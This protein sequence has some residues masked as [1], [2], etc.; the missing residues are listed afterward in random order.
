M[1]DKIPIEI[2]GG[3]WRHIDYVESEYTIYKMNMEHGTVLK[4]T[5]YFMSPP[6]R[7]ATETDW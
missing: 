7:K 4:F 2:D 6:I 1:V 3:V 5:I